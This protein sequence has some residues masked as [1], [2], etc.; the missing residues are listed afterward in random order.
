[1][2]VNAAIICLSF[3]LAANGMAAAYSPSTAPT[4]TGVLG[5]GSDVGHIPAPIVV[6]GDSFINGSTVYWQGQP[7]A[8]TFVNLGKLTATVPS[9]FAA[10]CGDYLITVKQPDGTLS[11]AVH[12]I[13]QPVLSSISP[14]S[15]RVNTPPFT[16][17]ATGIGFAPTNYIMMASSLG[18]THLST[19]YVNSTTLRFVFDPGKSLLTPDSISVGVRDD[20]TQITSRFL[21]VNM[22]TTPFVISY[23]SPSAAVAGGPAFTLTVGGSGFASGAVVQWNGTPLA[24][25]KLSDYVL[26]ANVPSNLIATA[27]TAQ[28]SVA[29]PGEPMLASKAF[30]INVPP[31]PAI[32]TITPN[33]VDA[34]TVAFP[35]SVSG[36]G[37]VA[38]AIV[39]LSGT[40]L[41][42]TFVNAG[43]L[44]ASV[45]ASLAR[46][47]GR[48]SVTVKNPDGSVSTN[49]STLYVEPVLTAI[50]PASANAGS[51][52][53]PITVSG[54]GFT[55][56]D[57]IRINVAGTQADLPTTFA[58]STSLSATI[59]GTA[60]TTPASV[61]VSIVDAAVATFS[62]GQTFTVTA[63][64]PMISALTPASAVAGG[65]GFTLTVNGSGFLSGA[66]VKWNGAALQTTFLSAAAL[67]ATVPA[68]LIA[69][70]GSAAISVENAGGAVSSAT[71]FTIQ[72]LVVGPAISAVVNA[73][74]S[75][76]AIAPGSL[77]SIYGSKLSAAIASSPDAPLRVALEGTSVLLDGTAIPLLFVSPG[78]V[79]AQVPYEMRPGTI[80]VIVQS[81]AGASLPVDIKVAATA[82]GVLMA[83]QGNHALLWNIASGDL[84]SSDAPAKP[85]QYV[86]AYVTG[87]GLVDPPVVS[88][89]AAPV[90]PLSYPV[91]A[92]QVTVAGRPAEVQFAGL[93]PGFV[94]VLQLNVLIPDVPSGEQ[95]FEVSIGGVS[96]NVTQVSIGP[97]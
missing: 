8:T 52:S 31:P 6:E 53:V 94:G 71:S 67:S 77:I 13:V 48:F 62:R 46:T 90:S 60:L 39:S 24:T 68:S 72:P 81:S 95:I 59:P 4:I 54:L 64:I 44:T 80:K 45:P 25:S 97:K 76:P 75:L 89:A 91:A 2:R 93:A 83:P 50:S 22:L 92:V 65:A 29:N 10:I 1:M 56:T 96:A 47:S 12:F 78:Q 42:T 63:P 87:Q 21:I 86:T 43:A 9:A 26:S 57:V 61:A 5:S 20:T 38:G 37:F 18:Q 28:I 11:N 14:S 35:L 69:T 3:G 88:G 70:A 58:A 85:G 17:T 30:S 34:G 82:P 74:S 27:G 33:Q 84:N 32:S 79:N 51:A 15:V 41:G 49:S 66:T 23:F 55:P 7:L 40:S 19:T 16:I 36:S 73:L